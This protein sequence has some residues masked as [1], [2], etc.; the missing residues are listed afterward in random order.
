[1]TARISLLLPVLM[2]SCISVSADSY[3]FDYQ[4]NIDISDKA[5][6]VVINPVGKIEIRGDQSPMISIS[7]VKNVRAADQAEAE[8]MAELI[9]IKV[10]KSGGKVTIKTDYLKRTDR[11]KSFWEKLFGGGSDSFGSVDFLIT[12]PHQCRIDAK[13]TSGDISVTDVVGNIIIL[14][15]SGN[16][17][18]ENIEGD[19]NLSA[20]SG[21]ISLYG[22]KGQIEVETASSDMEMGSIIGRIDIHSTSGSKKGDDISGMVTI[23]QTSGT[24]TLNR[25]NGDLRI[26]STSGDI[27]IGQEEGSINILSHSGRVEIGTELVSD[28]DYYVETTTGDI[29]FKVPEVSSGSVRLETISGEISAE[30]PMSVKASSDKKLTGSFGK[31]GPLIALITSSGDVR[32][33]QY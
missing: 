15:T 23:A 16:Q 11:S 30:I 17:R 20:I 1:M 7:A 19:V 31:G 21:G 29:L 10:N 4:K 8:K 33:E 2:L 27:A 5:E 22:I 26:K 3:R 24:V 14:G 32:L 12:V 6:L 25:L 9:E 18:L 13:N 28:R